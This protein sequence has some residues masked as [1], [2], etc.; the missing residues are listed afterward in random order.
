MVTYQ[1]IAERAYFKHLEHPEF[2]SL[3]NWSAAT[4]EELLEEKIKQEAYLLHM[5]THADSISDYL[6]AKEFVNQRLN[7]LAYYLHER[8]YNTKPQ[9]NWI[10][11]QNMYINNF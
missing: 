5:R 4:R 11:A 9:E 8:A 3:H 7:L 10:N 6:Q 1:N 2:D